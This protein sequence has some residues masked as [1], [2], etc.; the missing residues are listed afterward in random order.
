MPFPCVCVSQPSCTA[1]TI[2][3]F[4]RH[5]VSDGNANNSIFYRAPQKPTTT[6]YRAQRKQAKTFANTQ[7]LHDTAHHTSVEVKVFLG[8]LIALVNELSIHAVGSPLEYFVG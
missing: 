2:S 4:A 1:K 5:V 3:M 8:L 6:E 7:L